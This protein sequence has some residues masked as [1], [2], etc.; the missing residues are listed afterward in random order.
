MPAHRHSRRQVTA[1]AAVL[2]LLVLWAATAAADP[3]DSGS[4]L[5]FFTQQA[6]RATG[7]AL[8]PL[9]R[10]LAIGGLVAAVAIFTWVVLNLL[11]RRRH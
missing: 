4:A 2:A 10:A 11:V 6:L 9:A 7:H 8:D 1:A 3:R 5:A